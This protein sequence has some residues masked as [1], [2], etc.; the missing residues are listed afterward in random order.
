M[1]EGR[2]VKLAV[3]D[4]CCPLLTVAV[5]DGGGGQVK[6]AALLQHE[7]VLATLKLRQATMT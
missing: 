7:K 2:R 6:A 3:T 4:R 5:S 1:A